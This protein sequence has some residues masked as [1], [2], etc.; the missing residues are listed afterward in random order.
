MIAA[1]TIARS[2]SWKTIVLGQIL[3]HHFSLVEFRVNQVLSLKLSGIDLNNHMMPW[4][5][6]IKRCR[7]WF[8]LMYKNADA[9]LSIMLYMFTC[10]DF[11]FSEQIHHCIRI[12]ENMFIIFTGQFRA[13]Q[14]WS[15]FMDFELECKVS[16]Y[17]WDCCTCCLSRGQISTSCEGKLIHVISVIVLLYTGCRKERFNT[18][19]QSFLMDLEHF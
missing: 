3:V 15:H 6:L 17:T 2:E 11:P 12:T 10:I 7:W 5:A 18:I 16:F 8:E 14:R 9:I 4:G 1:N 13:T 19:P